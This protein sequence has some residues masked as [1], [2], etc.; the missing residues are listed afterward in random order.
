MFLSLRKVII[1]INDTYS[2]F[3]LCTKRKYLVWY[4]I[5]LFCISLFAV[6]FRKFLFPLGCLPKFP[7]LNFAKVV[8]LTFSRDSLPP[9][10]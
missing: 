4:A 8:F 3:Q 10:M 5:R 6:Y 7:L 9:R 1:T 2:I